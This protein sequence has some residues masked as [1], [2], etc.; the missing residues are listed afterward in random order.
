M[1]ENLERSVEAAEHAALDLE[2]PTE[3]RVALQKVGKHRQLLWARQWITGILIGWLLA[4]VVFNVLLSG[5]ALV[6][7]WL[8]HDASLPDS[9]LILLAA[10]TGSQAIT[11]PV[12]WR[13]L[14]YWFR[15]DS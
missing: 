11:V 8:G 2:N 12:F 13:P 14:L 5:T 6:R 9:L 1:N 15:E 10:W 7:W 4:G 3:R